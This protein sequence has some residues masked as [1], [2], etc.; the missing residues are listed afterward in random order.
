MDRAV[1]ISIIVGALIVALSAAYYLVVFLPK[2]EQA[3]VDIQRQQL[4]MQKAK[5]D[6]D[7]QARDQE[8]QRIEQAMKDCNEEAGRKLKEVSSDIKS[9]NDAV[10]VHD[11]VLERCFRSKGLNPLSKN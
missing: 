9:S 5:E 10:Q 2:K 8:K 1:K 11:L 6:A 4:D 3:R 7:A